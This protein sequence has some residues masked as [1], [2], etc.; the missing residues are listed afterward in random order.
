MYIWKSHT[1]L[2]IYMFMCLLVYVF[3][4]L[5][6]Y[7]FTCLCVY[8]FMCLCVYVF[9]FYVFMFLRVYMFMYLHVNI[10]TCLH[11]YLYI[12]CNCK[13]I[14]LVCQDSSSKIFWPFWPYISHFSVLGHTQKK[15]FW[16]PDL[17]N[18]YAKFEPN[19]KKFF[20]VWFYNFLIWDLFQAS[21]VR[22][23]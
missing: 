3:T 17:K 12:L 2:H 4:C 23:S 19:P 20:L 6:L 13:F 14:K 1:C 22:P 18:Q 21:K 5:C 15:F 16:I 7:V 9:M 8:V 10:F 11:V